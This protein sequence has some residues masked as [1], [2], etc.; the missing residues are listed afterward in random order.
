[1][2]EMGKTSYVTGAKREIYHQAK[3]VSV[4]VITEILNVGMEITQVRL[5][6]KT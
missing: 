1:M 3:I 5:G 6:G 4:I 2:R